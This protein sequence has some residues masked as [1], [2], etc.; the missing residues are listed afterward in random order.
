M[1]VARDLRID[2]FRG[3]ALLIVLV[4]HVEGWAETFVL[5][6]WTLISL[7]FSDA[8][9]IFV[10]LSGYVFAS[11]Y[12]RTLDRFGLAATL[13]KAGKR[14]LQ[15]YLAYLLAA[16]TVVAVGWMFRAWDPPMMN[17]G[18]RI[19]DRPWA[20][21]LAALTL[22]FHP[23]G[24]DILAFYVPIL[25]VMALLLFVQRRNAP[26][27]WLLSGGMYLAVQLAP[28]L[29]LTRFAD[30]NPWYFNP[31]AWQFLFFIG[32]YL[33]DPARTIKWPVPRLLLAG[34]LAVVAF[35]VYTLKIVPHLVSVHPRLY[36]DALPLFE[37]YW[38]WSDKTSLEPLRLLHFFALVY[39]TAQLLPADLR[40]WSSRAARPLVVAGQ[41]SLEVYAWGLVLS[42]LGAFVILLG[43]NSTAAVVAIDLAACSASIG[44][45]FAVRWWKTRG[46]AESRA[47]TVAPHGFAVAARDVARRRPAS[48]RPT[49]K[50]R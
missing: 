37:F 50:S 21:M 34:S 5:E 36:L 26:L 11:A 20:S 38:A 16:L 22:R 1:S 13:R 45:A 42:F 6:S 47:S 32:I 24:F 7:G 33:G 4:D 17:G 12:S 43:A 8:A 39:A 49:R 41:H 10:F 18:L 30:G 14:S 31:L 40:F 9:E 25:P 48:T 23:F 19:G 27:A 3:L 44:F 46:R 29:N 15:I 28:G 2:F 35:G